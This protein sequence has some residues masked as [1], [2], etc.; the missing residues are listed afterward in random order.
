MLYPQQRA[1]EPLTMMSSEL[2]FSFFP[3]RRGTRRWGLSSM[4]YVADPWAAILTALGN[5]RQNERNTA[6]SFVRQA[7]EYFSAAERATAI[8]TRPLLYYYSFLNLT[9]ALAL[10]RH[11]PGIVGKVSHGINLIGGTSHTVAGQEWEF[12]ER[13][14]LGSRL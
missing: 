8:E 10:A 5:L 6:E 2:R 4:I 9:K 12:T 1:G 3:M 14:P 7:Q 13:I 11:R